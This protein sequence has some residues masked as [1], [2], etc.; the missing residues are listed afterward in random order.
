MSELFIEKSHKIHGNR[1][2]YSNINYINSKTE[3]V[4]ICPIHGKFLQTP[5]NHLQ[6]QGCKKCSDDRKRLTTDEFIKKAIKI[7]G[8][9]Y[10]YSHSEYIDSHHK[11]GIICSIHGIF[12][13]TANDHLSGYGCSQCSNNKQLTTTEFIKKAIKIHGLLYDYSCVDYKNN[14]TKIEILCKKHGAF[15]QTPTEHIDSK[16]GCPKCCISRGEQEIMK[17][18][19]NRNIEYIHQKSFPDC[20]NPKT[21][22]RLKFDFYIPNKNLLIEYDGE[23]HFY[24]GRIVG[25]QYTTTDED[26]KNIQFRDNIKTA[27]SQAKN[28]K[29]CRIP[30]TNV[31]LISTI[32]ENVI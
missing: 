2:D 29:L 17:W 28:I 8:L 22:H 30:Y 23:Q 19:T 20:L 15:K 10:N 18:L 24:T 11:L 4:I 14:S 25:G 3:I 27:Y 31:K 6:G 9:L 26:L 32:L 13:Q 7:H 12:F 21:N 16:N 5:S 1:Y